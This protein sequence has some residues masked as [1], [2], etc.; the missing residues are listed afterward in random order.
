MKDFPKI[1]KFYKAFLYVKYQLIRFCCQVLFKQSSLCSMSLRSK[2]VGINIKTFNSMHHS[3]PFLSINFQRIVCCR[4]VYISLTDFNPL[5]GFKSFEQMLPSV[6]QFIL[7]ELVLLP[8]DNEAKQELP[9]FYLFLSF[10]MSTERLCLSSG[11]LLLFTKN[12]YFKR[13]GYAEIT[14]SLL[15]RYLCQWWRL[16]RPSDKSKRQFLFQE[17]AFLKLLHKRFVSQHIL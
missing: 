14:Q 17:I 12:K 2:E 11:W 5:S 8:V 9:A 3:H 10:C 16:K 13:S 15:F 1:K 7:N 6:S 4:Q